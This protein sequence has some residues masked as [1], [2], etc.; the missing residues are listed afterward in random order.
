MKKHQPITSILCATIIK[1]YNFK[2]CSGT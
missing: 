2:S 1:T